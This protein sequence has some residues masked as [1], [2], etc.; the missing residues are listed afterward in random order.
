M[1][2]QLASGCSGEA[3]VSEV[4][5]VDG[6]YQVTTT[7]QNDTC[8]PATAQ[9]SSVDIVEGTSVVLNVN[10]WSGLRQDIPLV[11]GEPLEK[12]QCAPE[13]TRRDTPIFRAVYTL[14]E[15]T[16]HS[17]KAASTFDWNDP[18]ACPSSE[19]VV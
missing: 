15:L 10:L 6:F 14:S 19:P 12:W 5:P 8:S 1:A 11:K 18:T 7:T 16:S 17:F 3:P 9:G 2:V 4:R 13:D